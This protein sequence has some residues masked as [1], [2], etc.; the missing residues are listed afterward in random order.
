[1]VLQTWSDYPRGHGDFFPPQTVIAL[2]D[3]VFCYDF[4][5]YWVTTYV[6]LWISHPNQL[7]FRGTQYVLVILHVCIDY[8]CAPTVFS[9][10]IH[11]IYIYIY[12]YVLE[13]FY[14]Y[15][16]IY[17]CICHHR[18]LDMREVYIYIYIYICMS[19]YIHTWTV[20][21]SWRHHRSDDFE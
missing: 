14:I 12:I 17:I 8:T 11:N 16:Y 6:H 1:M 3:H 9:L 2:R 13:E 19:V 15:I 21:L 4:T 10:Y 20:T 7:L 18:W 5:K